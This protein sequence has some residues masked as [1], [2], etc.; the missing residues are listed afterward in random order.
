MYVPFQKCVF[1]SC[2]RCQCIKSGTLRHKF[3]DFWPSILS[4]VISRLSIGGS[5]HHYRKKSSSSFF[6]CFIYVHV[7]C[8]ENITSGLFL[9]EHSVPEEDPDVANTRFL[10]QSEELWEALE[11]SGWLLQDKISWVM[12]GSANVS[13]EATTTPKWK[14]RHAA[15][16]CI[17]RL[18][19][20]HTSTTRA[21]TISSL[22]Q[23]DVCEKPFLPNI[24]YFA[25][26][27]FEIKK[28][29]N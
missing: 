11:A 26:E 29:R 25:I 10:A 21:A 17:P 3:A 15:F 9:I 24:F 4:V 20:T 5:G 12:L 28:S 6:Y 7:L 8:E 1:G 18:T 13:D 27:Q 2:L 19:C 22:V 23:P 16:K 14:A